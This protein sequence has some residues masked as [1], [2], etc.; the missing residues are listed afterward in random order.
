MAI[1][2]NSGFQGIFGVSGISG[3]SLPKK[4]QGNF[5]PS[6]QFLGFRAI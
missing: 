2:A 5:R 3:Q 6:G 1:R 4:F